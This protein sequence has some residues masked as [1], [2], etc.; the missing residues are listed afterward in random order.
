MKEKEH[1]K[2]GWRRSRP[3]YISMIALAIALTGVLGWA[4]ISLA[5]HEVKIQVDGKELHHKTFKRTVGDVLT[6]AGVQVKTIDRVTPDADEKVTDGM[7]VVVERAFPVYLVADGS[8]D[9]IY[10]TK[11]S[12]KDVI[13]LASLSLGE[14][15]R[16]NPSLDSIV[17]PDCEIRVTRVAEETITEQFSIPAASERKADS[18]LVKGQQ[19]VVREGTPGEGERQIQVVYEDGKEVARKTIQEQVVRAPVSRIVAYGTTSSISRGGNVIR[20]RKSLQVRATA[21]GPSTGSY[22]ATGHKVARGMI[23]VD[24][25]VI[26]LGTRLYVD[27]YGYGRALDVGGAI[28]GNRID[29]FLPSEAECRRWGVRTVKVYILE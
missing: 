17:E 9:T 29:V 14:K 12:V 6:E 27:G 15:D 23:A 1:E 11:T 20:F 18:S 2:K 16:V 25:R 24:P 21:Y 4:T 19:R 26:P 10:T 22:T 7:K 13:E 3:F 5:R 8:I 28:K